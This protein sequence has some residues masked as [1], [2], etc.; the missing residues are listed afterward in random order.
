MASESAFFDLDPRRVA[1]VLIDFQNDFC[2]PKV[3]EGD[4]VI[5]THNAIAAARANRFA[6]DAHRHGAQVVYTRQVFDPA[7]LTER[8]LRTASSAELCAA[9]SWGAELFIEPISGSTV[10]VKDRYDCWR[11]D[12]FI[13]HLEAHGVDGLV[14][15]GVELVCCVLYAILGAAERGYRYLV[16]EHLVSGQD[17]GDETDNRAIR[18]WLRYNQSE[19]LI[20]DENVILERWRTLRPP[21]SASG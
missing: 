18:D 15:C 13:G 8:Q 9:G 14:I 20:E 11:S 4:K 12:E 2:R 21:V 5:N 17:V 6:G 10:A 1:V 3:F 16:P 19:H 7:N